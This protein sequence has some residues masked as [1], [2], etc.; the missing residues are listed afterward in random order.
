[1]GD[2]PPEIEPRR[3]ATEARDR[4]RFEEEALALADQVY[5][6]ARRLVRSREEAEDLVQDTYARAFRSWQ[7]YTPGTNMRAWLLRILTNLNVDR[8]R[9]TQRTPD[10]APLEEGDY[11]LANKLASSAGEEALEQDRVVERLSQDSVVD[12]LSSLS[13][14]FRDVVVLV[15]IGEFSYADAAQI[16]DVPI[17]TVMSRLHRGRRQLKQ[18]LA[19][20]AIT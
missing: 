5:R 7:S 8:G 6:V 9:K 10:L 1:M 2:A 17:G 20:E 14:D 15:D 19:E 16:L 4:V 18:R 3:L 12:A 13:H 11:F